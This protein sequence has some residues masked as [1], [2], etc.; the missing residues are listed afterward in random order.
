[1]TIKL[2]NFKTNEKVIYNVKKPLKYWFNEVLFARS[3]TIKS[4]ATQKIAIK[5]SQASHGK[6]L[7]H[8]E[9]KLAMVAIIIIDNNNPKIN[10]P[11]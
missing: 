3:A 7:T 11:V 6:D 2:D 8:L 10:N 1:M 4:R 9:I 5:P